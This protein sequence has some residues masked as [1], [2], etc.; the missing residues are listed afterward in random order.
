[1]IAIAEELRLFEMP[2]RA[3]WILLAVLLVSACGGGG[4]SIAPSPV[5]LPAPAPAPAPAAP[6]AFGL[7]ER[8]APTALSL[9]QESSG[10]GTYSTENAFPNLSFTLPVFATAVPGRN[11]LAVVEQ[12]GRILQF[13]NDRSTAAAST[14]LDLGGLT[15]ADA[16]QGLLGLAFDP[17]FTRNGFLYVHYIA[18]AP[19]RSVFSRFTV[20]LETLTAP[21]A[22]ERVLLEVD[23]PFSNHNAGMVAFGPDGMLY[24]ALGDGG[25]GG[26]P[27]N[28][29]QDSLTL[30]GNI[31]RI[32]PNDTTS[33]P[34]PFT[35][36]ADNPFTN[37]PAARDEIWALGFRNPYRFSFDRQTGDLWVGDV[38]QNAFEEVDLVTRGGNYGWR[39]FEGNARFDD[40]ANTLPDS[41]F[42]PPV[43]VYGRDVG[44]SV[45][46]GY[47][48]RGTRIASLFGAY[49]YGDFVSGLAFALRYDGTAVTANDQ[50]A[51]VPQLSSFAEDPTGDVL[52]VSYTGSLFRL[53][54]TGA[55][56]VAIASRLSETGAF[57][58]L[59][60]LTPAPGYIEYDLNVPFHSDGAIKRRWIGVP[61]DQPISFSPTDPWD[62]P[63]GTA[64]IKHFE[65]A[66]DAAAPDV[67]RR[68][69]TRF[70]VRQAD[71]WRSYTYRWNDAQ[72][73]AE[74]VTGR[75]IVPLT[76]ADGE[77]LN[78]EIP[79]PTDCFRC[80]GVAAGDLLG[81]RTRQLNRDFAFAAATDNQLRAYDNIN[82]LA[83]ASSSA[84]PLEAYPST[85]DGDADLET[86][87]RAYLDVNCA[88][89]H[90]PG[91]GTG[92][93]LDLRFD[94]PTAQ[95]LSVDVA[96]TR[97]DLGV[98]DA[99][100]IAP[101]DAARSVLA[102][103]MRR[104]DGTRM[105]PLATHRVDTD[106]VNLIEAW[107][108]TLAP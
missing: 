65:M 7:T 38:G 51:N 70:L 35:I 41:A 92:V 83:P 88:H 72:S 27:L 54:E 37:D 12:G 50:I 100:I 99:R 97:G 64:V 89:C 98:A 67:R 32:D 52:L 71:G 60:A 87:A 84:A 75:Q 55:E 77:T 95:T 53:V 94:T 82:L 1:M 14:M 29:G 34:A 103:R 86:R 2:R 74:L 76:F 56:A 58:D 25:S 59:A 90:A 47:V 91:G 31:L 15:T 107:I 23:Q 68:L 11:R 39:V 73:D 33:G 102:L 45:T 30:L 16:E 3:T 42:T 5:A 48:Y 49:L 78:Y 46:G 22:S 18:Q 19:R 28:A 108:N 6:Q 106:G 80:H 43:L 40:S 4:G 21:L 101:G 69:E 93:P 105:P 62:F 104:L 61:G 66:L 36:P 85:A 8:I 10:F 44:S 57:S 9:P 17:D 63:V 13:E 24:L 79:A 96:P 26:D 20:D 81:V